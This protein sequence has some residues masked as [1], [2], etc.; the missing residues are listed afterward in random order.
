VFVDTVSTT[1]GS[2]KS[3]VLQN[4]VKVS[5][6]KVDGKWLIDNLAVPQS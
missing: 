1:Q 3:Q 6:Q 5:F 2:K 4:R